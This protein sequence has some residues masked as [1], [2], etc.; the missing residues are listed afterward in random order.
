MT[1]A[2]FYDVM[3]TRTNRRWTQLIYARGQIC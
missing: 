1:E 2:R 3:I